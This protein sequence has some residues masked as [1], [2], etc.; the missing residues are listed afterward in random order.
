MRCRHN[1]IFAAVLAVTLLLSRASADVF[2]VDAAG[3]PGVDF[4]DIP[5]AVAAA[6]DGDVILVRGTATYTWPTIS[7]LGLVIAADGPP[8]A[9]SGPFV[10]ED[11]PA[12]SSV[13]LSGLQTFSL[14]PGVYVHSPLVIRD[15]EGPVLARDCVFVS[16]SASSSAGPAV[17]VRGDS[18]VTLV[19]CTL[20]EGGSIGRPG[21]LVEDGTVFVQGCDLFGGVGQVSFG[22]L[23]GAPGGAGAL[24]RGGLVLFDGSTLTGGTGPVSVPAE[25]CK[26]GGDGG[27]ALQVDGAAGR[28]VV[29]DT[30]L[31]PGL[32]GAPNDPGSCNPGPPG[33]PAEVVAGL[34][35]MVAD[36][37][38]GLRLPAVIREQTQ[39][40]LEMDAPSG[41]G[42]FF[43]LSLDSAPLYFPGQKL[44]LH[45]AA[46]FHLIAGGAVPASGS[47]LVGAP[48][49]PN[50][51]S[52][53]T[54]H[55]QGAFVDGGGNVR[56]GNALDVVVLEAGL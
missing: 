45:P 7:G 26:D 16:S 25:P 28:V 46:G 44:A 54:I 40:T 21:L 51:T 11:V 50:G 48:F 17:T 23:G 5:A 8:V 6:S 52:S 20:V 56:L 31:T 33:L 55:A 12:G 30:V 38:R 3:G 19:D 39:V 42:A 34:L 41:E 35:T 9:M 49:L 37:S 43:L 29:R 14:F 15:C 27:P 47:T 1:P 18:S 53:V 13:T 10:I 22:P 4:A 2:V 24:V 36:T 32:G